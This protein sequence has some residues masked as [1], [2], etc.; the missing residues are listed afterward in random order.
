MSVE[1]EFRRRWVRKHPGRAGMEI[2]HQPGSRAA[3]P[4]ADA[5]AAIAD[6]AA[7]AIEAPK[8]PPRTPAVAPEPDAGGA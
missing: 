3:L 2:H 4:D 5:K 8:A 1:V 6:G 7:V